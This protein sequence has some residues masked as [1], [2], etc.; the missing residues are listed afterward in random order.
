MKGCALEL[1]E[2]KGGG[3][4]DLDRVFE[5]EKRG[6]FVHRRKCERCHGFCTGRGEKTLGGGAPGQRTNVGGG[7]GGEVRWCEGRPET[8]DRTTLDI[9]VTVEEAYA[10]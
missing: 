9:L 8:G 7:G 1:K 10:C 4:G 5:R 6:A 2:L 3:G